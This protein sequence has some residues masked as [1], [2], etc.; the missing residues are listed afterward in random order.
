[1]QFQKQRGQGMTPCQ[2]LQ[3]QVSCDDIHQKNMALIS[4]V[5]HSI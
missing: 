4:N 1:M 3:T 2:K 5:W